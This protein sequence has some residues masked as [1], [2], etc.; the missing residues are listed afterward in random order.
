[1]SN[2]SSIRFHIFA[3]PYF[4]LLIL[5]G[6]SQL[7][8]QF[9][10]NWSRKFLNLQKSSHAL[11]L[12]VEGK[13]LTQVAQ[14]TLADPVQNQT[15]RLFKNEVSHRVGNWQSFGEQLAEMLVLFVMV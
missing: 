8:R 14:L 2:W 15:E 5:S 12:V 7:K 13:F 4:R 11:D 10:N 3:F 6:S 1:M 9:R